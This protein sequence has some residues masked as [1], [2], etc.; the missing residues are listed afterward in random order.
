MSLEE[1]HRKICEGHDIRVTDAK[2]GTDITSKVLLQV[3][4]EYEP[5]KMDFFS[6]EMLLQ[7]IRV[8]D[9]I[10]KDFIESYLGSM[11]STFT[12]SRK[13][14]EA[15]VKQARMVQKDTL[16]PFAA[17]LEAMNPF[18]SMFGGGGGRASSEDRV[19]QELK[20]LRKE[21]EDLKKRST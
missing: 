20:V 6:S 9:K 21:V 5:L 16:N 10:Q 11:F 17:S 18:A 2:S 19:A 3:L 15:F 13:N 12:D 4:I 14:M 8:N 1:I 7:I